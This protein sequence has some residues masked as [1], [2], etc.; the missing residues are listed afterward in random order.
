MKFDII[1]GNPP[2]QNLKEGNKKSQHI[3]DR[4]VLN[5]LKYLNNNGYL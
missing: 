3:W 5:S 4:F 2:F 1:I